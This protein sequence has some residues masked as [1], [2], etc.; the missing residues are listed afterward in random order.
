MDE[1]QPHPMRYKQST[2]RLNII[3]SC[4]TLRGALHGSSGARIT[5]KQFNEN[6]TNGL[7]YAFNKM[8]EKQPSELVKVGNLFIKLSN[9][10]DTFIAKKS[11]NSKS[12]EDIIVDL[13]INKSPDH[14]DIKVSDLGYIQRPSGGWS[15]ATRLDTKEGY[16]HIF[17]TDQYAWIDSSNATSKTASGENVDAYSNPLQRSKQQLGQASYQILGLF[18]KNNNLKVIPDPAG[19]SPIANIRRLDAMLAAS[20]RAKDTSF[21]ELNP[22]PPGWT[23][24]KNFA[25]DSGALAL[26]SSE[27]VNNFFPQLRTLKLSKNKTTFISNG[28]NLSPRQL[29]SYLLENGRP[30]VETGIGEKTLRRAILSQLD[31]IGQRLD[32]GEVLDG[33][34]EL[35]PD[36][37]RSGVS[38]SGAPRTGERVLPTGFARG[39]MF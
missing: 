37:E 12:I 19:V 14:K 36:H 35:L 33:D 1:C 3:G 28:S 18:A 21:I 16:V 5:P 10:D 32:I 8:K 30:S 17:H 9:S 4:P 34:A 11:S 26:F 31:Q 27:Y 20:L 13:G 25:Q 23:N 15:N 38:T 29:P 39:I 2:S 22:P 7:N 24:G 6:V